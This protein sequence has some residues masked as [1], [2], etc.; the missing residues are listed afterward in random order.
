MEIRSLMVAVALA[1]A[2]LP[3]SLRA[4]VYH[5]VIG[6]QP[7]FSD[8]PCTADAKPQTVAPPTAAAPAKGEQALARQYDADAASAKA[9]RDRADA[10]WV[11][12]HTQQA[13][14]AE[15]L[16]R[17]EIEGRV[18]P[19]MTT[20]QVEHILNLPTQITALG[21]G[22]ERWVYREGRERRTLTFDGGILKSVKNSAS[23]AHR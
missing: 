11:A 18:V 19:G 21:E 23:K 20:D 8:Q 13:A 2:V 7:V 22:R 9:R 12:A 17:A 14:Q 4:A 5:C 6:G 1:A 16:R 3:A 10:A 15:A